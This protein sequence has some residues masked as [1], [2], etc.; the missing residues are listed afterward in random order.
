MQVKNIAECFQGEHS[1]ILST[2]IKLP[3]IFAFPFFE[4][5]LNTCFTV[6]TTYMYF[7]FLVIDSLLVKYFL[8]KWD[9]FTTKKDGST[10]PTALESDGP[11]F[12][13]MG[14][15]PGPTINLKACRHVLISGYIPI[16]G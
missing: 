8:L 1:A 7:L 6:L 13:I 12:E 5:L 9:I 16:L 15:W 3:K 14:Q 10:G 4:W 2:F 11:Y